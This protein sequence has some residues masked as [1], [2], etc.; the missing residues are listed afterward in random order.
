MSFQHYVIKDAQSNDVIHTTIQTTG[1]NIS[2]IEKTLD[3][4][5]IHLKSVRSLLKL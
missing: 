3:T 1:Y 2:P 4:Q 5:D